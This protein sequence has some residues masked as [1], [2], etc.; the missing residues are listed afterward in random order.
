MYNRAYIKFGILIVIFLLFTISF[1]SASIIVGIDENY[2]PHEYVKDGEIKGFNVDLMEAIAN[3]INESVEFKPMKWEFAIEALKNGSIDALFMAMHEEREKFFDFSQPILDLKLAIFVKENIYGI[4]NINDLAGHTVAVEADDIA[5]VILKEKVPEAIIIEVENQSKALELVE[6]GEAKAFFGNYYTGLYLINK[7]GYEDIKIIGEKL[8]IGKRCIAVK[9]GN[10]AL[11]NKLNY[12]IEKIKKSGKYD[13][14]YEIWFGKKVYYGKGI[15]KWILY[16]LFA[17]IAIIAVGAGVLGV[18]NYVLKRKVDEKTT[19]IITF[20]NY[21]ENIL[22]NAPIAILRVDKDFKLI[23]ENPEMERLIGILI[24]KESKAMG[25]DLRELPSVKKFLEEIKS[26]DIFEKLLRGE[27]IEGEGWFTSIYGKP[28][29]IRFKGIPLFEGGK[30]SGAIFIADDITERKKIEG[31]YKSLIEN[32]NDVIYIISSD[33]FEYVNPAFEKLF[34]YKREEICKKEFDIWQ[35]IH[36][37]DREFIKQREKARKEGKE[38]SSR[39]EFRGIT[40]DGKILYLE[41]STVPL[42][43]ERFRV[44]GILRDVTE[45]VKAEEEIKKLMEFHM[46]IGRV[47]NRSS[48][49]KEVCNGILSCIK[50][51]IKYDSA[52]IYI[53]EKEK[54][55][56]VAF[57]GFSDLKE[58]I[59]EI[60]INCDW[61][62]VNIAKTGKVSIKNAEECKPF[63]KLKGKKIFSV[64][65]ITSNNLHGIIQII[66]SE[67]DEKAMSIIKNAVEEIAAGILKIKAEEETRKSE[68]KYRRLVG[69]AVEGIYRTTLDGKILEV[70]PALSRMFGYSIEEFS[71]LRVENLY[72]DP[73]ER[74]KF[75]R[76]L[77]EKGEIK[78]YEIEY[79]RKDGR[80]LIARESARLTKEGVI[81]GILHDVTEEKLFEKKLKAM[82]E[83]SDALIG[84]MELDEIY[85]KSLKEI[86]KALGADGGVIF[87]LIENELELK[88]A[89]GLSDE[90]IRK[91]KRIPLGKH[92][93]G[94]VATSGESILIEDSHKDKRCTPEVIKSEKYRSAIVVPIYLKE[95]IVGS[96]AIISKKPNYFTYADIETLRSIANAIAS[97]INAARLHK[98]AI[99]ALQK[100]RDFKLRTAHYFFNPICIAK[101]YLELAKGENGKDKIER[102]LKAINRIE[103]VIKNIT[104]KGEIIE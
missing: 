33:G 97:A 37:E 75:I 88:K 47:V 34:G 104:Q 95:K 84:K 24:D 51:I 26:E 96:M 86:V 85:E 8:D 90:Y 15:P 76:K 55:I 4:A 70:N 83:V 41:A 71:K 49:I 52:I 44:L 35:L 92:L 68:E 103:K 46:S 18:G 36:P 87:E 38:L 25:K 27:R 10:H 22:E 79:I 7:L 39:Y 72:K 9:K 65:L 82:A 43:G 73:K 11:L 64:P 13:E 17:L 6:N 20:K 98:K 5:S 102:A 29:Y 53:H 16:S 94:K 100:E 50:E 31:E 69:N 30:F 91:Y 2:P 21:L 99:D 78:D 74:E 45:R 80:T 3:E 60:D 19:E 81:E 56:P 59:K 61:E 12:G 23:Y 54:L 77:K 89:E 32:A 63:E 28:S 14:I 66:S 40:K 101:G 57:E 42:P 58:I 62:V 93:V 1:S 48:S 67:I